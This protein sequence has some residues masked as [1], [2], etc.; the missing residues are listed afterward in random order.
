MLRLGR[1]LED[2]R[3]GWYRGDY[4]GLVVWCGVWCCIVVCY[5]VSTSSLV[6]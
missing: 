1:G 4:E 5:Y 6:I 2:G 3:D